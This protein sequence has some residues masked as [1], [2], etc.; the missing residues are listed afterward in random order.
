MTSTT[1]AGRP[2]G[3]VQVTS[4]RPRAGSETASTALAAHGGEHGGDEDAAHE[5]QSSAPG[6]VGC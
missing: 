2:W 3:A 4:V 5:A 1:P 6:D